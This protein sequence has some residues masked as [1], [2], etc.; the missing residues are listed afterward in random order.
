MGAS[1]TYSSRAIAEE[2]KLL[3]SCLKTRVARSVRFASPRAAL[4]V[5]PSISCL[6]A[7]AMTL[8]P[9]LVMDFGM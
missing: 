2:L 1:I 6:S 7:V 8:I 4:F 3:S 5:D 9:G